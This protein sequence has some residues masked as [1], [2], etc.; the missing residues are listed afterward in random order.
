MLAK[1]LSPSQ[2]AFVDSITS[3]VGTLL[4]SQLPGK[5]SMVSYPPGF[6]PAIQYGTAA[7]Y[8]STMLDAFNDTL[9]IG[10][11]GML[12]LG[13]QQFS[14]LY[15]NILR[16]ATYQYSTADQKVV[17]DPNIANQ[18]I[19]VVNTATSSG[20]FRSQA[21]TSSCE[22]SISQRRIAPVS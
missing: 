11:N 3:E 8:N 13:N 20:F 17:N 7:Y 14:T 19:A 16:N 9:E 21:M 10:S 22:P 15:Y 18:Q 12:T 4:G 6:H 2:Q 1:Q 5:F